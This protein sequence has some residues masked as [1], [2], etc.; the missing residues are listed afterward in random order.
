MPERVAQW[1]DYVGNRVRVFNTYGPTETTVVATAA[2]LSRAEGR[3]ERVPIGRPL[4]NMRAYVLDGHQQPVPMGVHGELYIGGRSVG[5]G[6][7]NRPELTAERFVPDP[8]VEETGRADVQDWRRCS[9]AG[10]RPVWSSS[11]APITR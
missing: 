3:M 7:L 9:L 8:L 11:A 2:E 6:Y 10:R 5:R 1:F 4:T